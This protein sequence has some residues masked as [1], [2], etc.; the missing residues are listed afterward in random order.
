QVDGLGEPDIAAIYED[1]DGRLQVVSARWLVSQLGD[2]K[3]R[4]IHANIPDAVPLW[5]STVGFL[6]RTG[7]WWFIT[8]LGLYRFAH[9]RRVEDLV[10]TKPL[11]YKNLD[12]LPGQWVYCMFEDSRGDLWI[13]IRGTGLGLFGLV[14]WRRA[15]ETFHKLTEADGFPPGK[16]AASFAEDRAGNL[17]FGFYEGGLVRYPPG[18]LS[19]VTTS[20]VISVGVIFFLHVDP[21]RRL[22]LTLTFGRIVPTG[23]SVAGNALVIPLLIT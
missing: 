14:R 9:A 2:R 17:W 22:R 23:F 15:D 3:F 7:Q 16:S 6:D 8:N 19:S 1:R 20:I 13:S 18:P 10:H 21:I 4:S 12:G 5:S 11:L